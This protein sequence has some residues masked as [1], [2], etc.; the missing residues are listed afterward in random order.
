MALGDLAI[1]VSFMHTVSGSIAMVPSSRKSGLFFTARSAELD[2]ELTQYKA[3]ADF[4]DHLIPMDNLLEPGVAANALQALD[5]FM[6]DKA[7]ASFGSLYKDM[8]QDCLDDV[9]QEYAKAK[10]RL[11]KDENKTTYVPLPT[12]QPQPTSLKV[13]RRREKEKTRPTAERAYNITA[14]AAAELDDAVEAPPRLKV[15]ASTASVFATIFSKSEARGSVP[16]ADF[17][18]AMA[19]L[20]FSVT[21][22]GRSIFMFNPPESIDSRPITIH[23][24]HASDIDRYQL[25]YL[26]RRLNRVYRWDAET[27]EL[28]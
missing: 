17:A 24:P 16:W 14:I 28:I 6:V 19:E 9:E 18:A 23:R 21:P 12:F 1:I 27:F 8:V 25:V 13:Q 7:G 11:E 5:D 10:A 4:G 2:N 3:E 22:K 20:D 15:K 26:A